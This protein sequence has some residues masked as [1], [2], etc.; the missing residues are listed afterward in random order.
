MLVAVANLLG[1]VLYIASTTESQMLHHLFRLSD[2]LKSYGK[3]R[4]LVWNGAILLGLPIGLLS[5]L[6]FY[7]LSGGADD[8]RLRSPYIRVL[9]AALW[10]FGVGIPTG[11]SAARALW[12]L[13]ERNRK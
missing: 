7:I 9:Y 8:V 4:F 5:G 12:N 13:D 10:I 6:I 2:E 11:Y 1:L 3:S